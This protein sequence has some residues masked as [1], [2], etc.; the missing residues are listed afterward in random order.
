L[1]DA[2]KRHGEQERKLEKRRREQARA[3]SDVAIRR[4]TDLDPW[5]N[6]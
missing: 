6:E 1:V 3:N 4:R 2:A 5:T